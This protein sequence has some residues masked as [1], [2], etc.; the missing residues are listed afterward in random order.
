MFL[1]SMRSPLDQRASPKLDNGPQDIDCH[2][3]LQSVPDGTTV[4]VSGSHHD[5]I[6]WAGFQVISFGR[7]I[8]R[9][10]KS[11]PGFGL[12]PELDNGAQ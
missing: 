3:P 1:G 8:L 9:S 7:M 12:S 2:K 6:G 4:I 11:P 5:G 10:H